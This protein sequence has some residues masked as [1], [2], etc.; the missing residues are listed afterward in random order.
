LPFYAVGSGR[1]E[2]AAVGGFERGDFGD[3]GIQELK[4]KIQ[5]LIKGSN[6]N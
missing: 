6:N 5:S 1:T 2:E 4:N 3:E